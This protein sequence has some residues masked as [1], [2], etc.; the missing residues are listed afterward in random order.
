MAAIKDINRRMEEGL[1]K[2]AKS[3]FKR[4]IY[5]SKEFGLLYVDM[6]EGLRNFKDTAMKFLFES[7]LLQCKR[8][9]RA[10]LE[11]RETS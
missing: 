8:W 10:I 9:G 1:E 4:S 2:L 6:A 3:K 7:T 5:H 11:I